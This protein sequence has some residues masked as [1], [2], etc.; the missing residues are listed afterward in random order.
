MGH[1]VS[2]KSLA[3][4]TGG[5]WNKKKNG[6]TFKRTLSGLAIRTLKVI[7]EFHRSQAQAVEMSAELWLTL[8]EAQEII[9]GVAPE[10]PLLKRLDSLKVGEI[11]DAL[12]TSEVC[13]DEEGDCLLCGASAYDWRIGIESNCLACGGKGDLLDE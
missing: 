3:N 5:G 7:G 1:N 6:K 4:L 8:S 9:E 12:K 10:H 11:A 13:G 2:E